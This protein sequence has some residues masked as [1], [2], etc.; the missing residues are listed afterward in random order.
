MK[1]KSKMVKGQGHSKVK[2]ASQITVGSISFDLMEAI[3]SYFAQISITINLSS[4]KI[5][6]KKGQR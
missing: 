1:F 6:F 3:K 2:Y 5:L 4:W